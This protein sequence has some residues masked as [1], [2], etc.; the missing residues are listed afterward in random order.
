M[1]TKCPPSNVNILMGVFE[2]QIHHLP[3]NPN[4]DGG[5]IFRPTCWFSL[6][7]SET[8]KAVTLAFR[9]IQ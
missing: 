7:N 3:L 5:G 9:S 4:V 2:D 8:V 6:N 1:C